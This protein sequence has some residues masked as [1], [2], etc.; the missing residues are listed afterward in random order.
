MEIC[1]VDLAHDEFTGLGYYD[2]ER[3]G[4]RWRMTKYVDADYTN[5]YQVNGMLAVLFA[6]QHDK[7]WIGSYWKSDQELFEIMGP[8]DTSEDAFIMLA[9]VGSK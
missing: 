3:S 8:Y 9:L 6:D 4:T 2:F 1:D 7:W 5:Y